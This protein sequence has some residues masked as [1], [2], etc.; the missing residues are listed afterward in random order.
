M[1]HIIL[2][3]LDGSQASLKALSFAITT[4]KAFQDDL[5]L[6]HVIQDDH[7]YDD[8]FI[9]AEK[10]LKETTITY[11][12]KFRKGIPSIEIADEAKE[13]NVRQIIMGSLGMNPQVSYALG[14]V[15]ERVIPLA[16]CPVTFVS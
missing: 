9:E 16:P 6:L 11:T 14:S 1:N 10:I 8:V 12:T 7:N 13:Q 15:S 2:V 3:P 5:L 4:A